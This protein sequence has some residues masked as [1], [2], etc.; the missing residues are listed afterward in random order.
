MP[1]IRFSSAKKVPPETEQPLIDALGA[2]LSCIPGKD[3]KWTMVALDDGRP[4][5]FGG[6]KQEDMVFL[7]TKY[8]GHFS[9][10]QKRAY[11]RAAC[12]AV[13]ELLGTPID[14]ICVTIDEH[15]SWGALGDFRDIHLAE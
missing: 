8:V 7:D 12:R 13:H 2:A 14:R 11:V 15:E 10:Q 5:Y 9:F 4:M 3:P 1:F 6:Q